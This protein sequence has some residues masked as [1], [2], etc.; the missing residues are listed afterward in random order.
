MNEKVRH[1]S[2]LGVVATAISTTFNVMVVGAVL[3]F[4]VSMVALR[5]IQNHIRPRNPTPP[6][7]DAE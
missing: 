4:V 3:P 5:V 7:R 2:T 6:Y 1:P